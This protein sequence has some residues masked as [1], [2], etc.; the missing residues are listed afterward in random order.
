MPAVSSAEAVNYYAVLSHH[1]GI[2]AT[3]DQVERFATGFFRC[4]SAGKSEYNF[5]IS[6][7]TTRYS[8]LAGDYKL[9]RLGAGYWRLFPCGENQFARF[10]YAGRMFDSINAALKALAQSP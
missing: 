3:L 8:R 5:H 6:E 4:A 10:S 7:D 2:H 1:L 9:V